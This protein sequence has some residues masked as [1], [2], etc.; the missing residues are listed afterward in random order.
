M[1]L[2]NIPHLNLN[3]NLPKN[4]IEELKQ[5]RDFYGLKLAD[6]IS[7][8]SKDRYYNTSEGHAFKS[9][10]PLKEYAYYTKG[11]KSLWVDPNYKD[12]N[13]VKTQSW[14]TIP[15]TINWLTKNLCSENNMCMVALHKLKKQ[16]WVDW[17]SHGEIYDIGIV[18][19]SII[20]NSEDLS[21]V[22]IND[23]E[24]K[25]NYIEGQGYLFNGLQQHR[26]TNFGNEDR[27][28]L[29]VECLFKDQKFNELIENAIVDLGPHT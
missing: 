22:K 13:Y 9:Y 26:S 19:F 2:D 1:N 16:S 3:I 21:E 25:Q 14:H 20:T 4:C 28:H 5:I 12:D 29:V 27:L 11:S 8:E 15:N 17:H 24:F 18:H 7:Q 6:N 10:A 23:F